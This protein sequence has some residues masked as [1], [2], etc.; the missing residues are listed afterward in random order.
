M[1]RNS[2]LGAASAAVL[3]CLATGAFAQAAGTITGGG[4]TLAEFDYFV[5]FTTFNN[6]ASGTA[7]TFNNPAP[8]T[9][10]NILYWPAGSGSGQAAF[11]NDDISCDA[12]K[13]NNTVGADGKAGDCSNTVGGVN[14]VSYGASDATLT[15]TQIA[16]WASSSVGQSV[17]GNLIQLPSMGVGVGFPVVNKTITKNGATTKN[18]A[19]AGG[20]VLTDDDLCGI[21]SGKIT[22]WS[23]VTNFTKDKVTAGPISVAY[24]SDGSGT[25]FL[26][27]NHLSAV[28]TSSN[29]SFPL[30]LNVSTTFAA[31]FPVVAG[32]NP[33]TYQVPAN[34]V[35]EKGS[36]GIAN[37]LSN[38]LPAGT[39]VNNVTSAIGYLSPDFTTVDPMSNAF[40]GQD[41]PPDQ[42]SALVV[43]AVT[44]GAKPYIP[45]ATNVA[46]GLNHATQGQFLTAP[47][48]A[49]PASMPQN[50]VSLIQLTSQGYPVIGYTTFDFAQCYQ[51]ATVA[52]GIISFMM[53]HY[54][55]AAYTT[56]EAN[57]GFVTISKSGAKGFGNV[58]SRAI[59]SNAAN[60]NDNIQNTK[61]CTGK[62][63]G[64]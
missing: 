48:G 45:T 3:S 37:Y 61:V 5:E 54:N 50:Y 23:G 14:A 42:K 11:L 21:F 53:D 16:Q 56:T 55:T 57:N 41:S 20:L 44:N 26:L 13:V 59:L 64:R 60:Y 35:G 62:I 31:A 38:T 25:S 36:S 10:N 58:I 28:C 27:L 24:R 1:T 9:G 2:L 12:N 18:V 39:G 63:T 22:N 33:T 4:S 51:N 17:A 7:A 47:N 43:A 30:P 52:A 29:S 15:T 49:G 40:I 34:F 19:V 6:A 32:S 8:A 46:L